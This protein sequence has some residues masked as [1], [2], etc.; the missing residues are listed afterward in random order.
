MLSIPTVFV[1]NFADD[2]R[3]CLRSS[4][5]SNLSNNLSIVASSASGLVNHNISYLA[6][7]VQ[8]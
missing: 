8:Y 1:L 5:P 7:N 4:P 2:H 3:Q 6:G